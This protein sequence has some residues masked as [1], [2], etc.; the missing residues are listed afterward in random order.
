LAQIVTQRA[1][2]G[3][4]GHEREYEIQ[5]AIAAFARVDPARAVALLWPGFTAPQASPVPDDWLEVER[6]CALEAAAAAKLP[7]LR[8]MLANGSRSDRL[9]ALRVLGRMGAATAG[10]VAELR[11]LLRS[12]DLLER[13]EAM[14]AI[15]Q[16]GPAAAVAM[17]ELEAVYDRFPG[18]WHDLVVGLSGLG[19]AAEPLLLRGLATED[20]WTRRLASVQLAR[21][22]VLSE[23]ALQALRASPES[24]ALEAY[25]QRR[26]PALCPSMRNPSIPWV[27]GLLPRDLLHL[28]EAW[29]P[30]SGI[31]D[32]TAFLDDEARLTEWTIEFADRDDETVRGAVAHVLGKLPPTPAALA[33]L[34]EL[35]ADPA[36]NVRCLALL[37]L[38]RPECR[39]A[40][41]ALARAWRSEEWLDRAA[42]SV[43]LRAA[44]PR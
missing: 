11:P 21:L 30:A 44:L 5:P 40:L 17:A 42:A 15:V 26:W 34:Q 31:G 7:E 18:D 37:A 16:S 28:L 35:T 6:F 10:A 14:R 22:P 39:A 36:P 38:G 13:H 23:K 2:G 12:D 41:P 20:E 3:P 9:R 24:W 25:A 4:A 1:I 32:R 19:A 43:A 27:P 29:R 8:R 33:T